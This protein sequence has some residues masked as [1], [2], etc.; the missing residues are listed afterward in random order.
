MESLMR[1]LKHS[2]KQSLLIIA[3]LAALGLGTLGARAMYGASGQADSRAGTLDPSAPGR[4]AADLSTDGVIRNLQGYLANHGGDTVALSNLGIWYLQ[5]ARESGDPA[6]YGKADAVLKQSLARDGQNF[7]TLLGMG[8]LALARHQ[9][10]EALGWGARAAE[11]NPDNAAAQGISGDAHVELGEYPEAFAAFEKMA[12]LRP[13]LSSYARISYA[14]ELKGDVTGAIKAMQSAVDAGAP[15]AEGTNWARAQLGTLY[16]EHGDYSAAKAAYQSALDV[17]PAYAYANAGMANVR[18]AEGDYAGARGIYAQ[19]I[20]TLPLPQFVIAL[21]DIETAGGRP[22]DAAQQYALAAIEEK[23][24]A[25]SG[26]DVDA[27]LALFDADHGRDLPNSLERARAAYARRPSVGVAD[28]LAWTL[29]QNGDYAAA[30]ELSRSALRLGTQ[31]AL[32]YYHAGMIARALGDAAGSV[33]Y[34]RK[35]LALNPNFSLLY[36]ANARQLTTSASPAVE[37]IGKQRAGIY[38]SEHQR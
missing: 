21:G 6:W 17:S 16:F 26:V 14:R 20:K 28:V 4:A 12:D 3:V 31:S 7:R 22:N 25:A 13:D 9:F 19:V 34:L 23:L 24:F 32:M 27:E 5:K 1:F 18:A 33:E 30:Q 2:F 36:A 15:D 10:R 29:Y 11:L 37:I 38:A 8:S 35:A